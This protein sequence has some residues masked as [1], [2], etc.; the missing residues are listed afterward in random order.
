MAIMKKNSIANQG[1]MG[2]NASP[3]TE[4]APRRPGRLLPILAAAAALCLLLTGCAYDFSEE[5]AAQPAEAE[6]AETPQ[7]ISELVLS[8]RRLDAAHH[9]AY[10]VTDP[11]CT[12]TNRDTGE[13]EFEFALAPPDDAAT[14]AACYFTEDEANAPWGGSLYF[15]IDDYTAGFEYSGAFMRDVT[16]ATLLHSDPALP[17]ETACEYADSILATWQGSGFSGAVDAGGFR[18]FIC[19]GAYA[20][21]MLCAVNPA[22]L[23]P[24]EEE[25]RAY[26]SVDYQLIMDADPTEGS[27]FRMRAQ[28]LEDVTDASAVSGDGALQFPAADEDGNEYL[29]HYYVYDLPLLPRP[30]EWYTFYCRKELQSEIIPTLTVEGAASG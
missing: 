27:A 17:M 25:A 9:F 2:A 19:G 1:G 28:V 21:P 16:T 24:G 10:Y 6:E 15:L 29:M 23:A 26:S 7:E 5:T 3:P 8:F 11:A 4:K 22:D 20:Q 12:W 18:V 14:R 30:G 13:A